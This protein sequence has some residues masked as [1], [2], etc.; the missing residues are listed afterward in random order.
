LFSNEQNIHLAIQDPTYKNHA[1]EIYDFLVKN[2][3][4]VYWNYKYN[5]K[6]S[7]SLASEKKAQYII[8]VGEKEKTNNYF[9]LKNLISGEQ[10]IV[11]LNN[12]LDHIK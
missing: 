1:L 12:I 8:I 3:F 10:K 6:K 5:I 11:D 2:N 9:S 7:L 4:A